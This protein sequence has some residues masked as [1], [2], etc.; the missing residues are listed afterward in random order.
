MKIHSVVTTVGTVL[1]C[2]SDGTLGHVPWGA[3]LAGQLVPVVATCPDPEANI[4]LLEAPGSHHGIR[5]GFD[6]AYEQIMSLHQFGK[7]AGLFFLQRHGDSRYLRFDPLG[8]G[9]MG[10]AVFEDC[11]ISE[12]PAFHLVPLSEPVTSGVLLRLQDDF[13]FS[14]DWLK[15]IFAADDVSLWPLIP[16]FLKVLSVNDV[17]AAWSA[18]SRSSIHDEVYPVIT[19]FYE[20]NSATA[21]SYTADIL[22]DLSTQFGWSIGERSHGRPMIFEPSLGKL[23]IGRYCSL[24][25]PQII[26]GNHI[27]T[28]TTSYPFM[29]LWPQWPG[30]YIGLEDHTPRDVVIGNDVRIDVGAIILPGTIIGDGAVIAAG[31]VV[32]GTVAPYSIVAGIPAKL[33]RKRFDNETIA[34]L[35]TLKWWDWP[36]DV[37]DR[38]IH[39]LLAPDPHDFLDAAEAEFGRCTKVIEA[40]AAPS[41]T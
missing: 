9:E 37:V 22:K 40:S 23:T 6:G 1:V 4:C 29:T 28:S 30:T 10:I 7:M 11:P 5:V 35:L 15:K 41:P 18:S 31:A 3:P 38:F 25:D 19:Q 8:G 20:A 12:A 16:D 14:V 24:A 21:S 27:T 17:R 33:Q 32:G 36:D 13:T 39:L 26:L 34:R 2:N